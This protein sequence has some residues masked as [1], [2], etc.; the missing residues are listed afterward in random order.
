MMTFLYFFIFLI[1]F[2]W[3]FDKLCLWLER[4]G[5]LYYKHHKPQS[6]LIGTALQ[7][8]NAQLVPSQRHAVVAKQEKHCEQ[9]EQTDKNGKAVKD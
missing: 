7:E 6:G 4:K 3:L 9:K 8:L 2:L 5:W 1:I